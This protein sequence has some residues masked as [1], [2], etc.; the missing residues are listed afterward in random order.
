M[1]AITSTGS[2]SEPCPYCFHGKL[3][4]STTTYTSYG[5]VYDCTNCGRKTYE[6]NTSISIDE[7]FI[8]DK[9]ESDKLENR[10][11]TWF[12]KDKREKKLFNLRKK[13]K[14]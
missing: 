11:E 1:A 7:V 10:R 6:T 12:E 5:K 8:S 9:P 3:K 14:R 4:E 13:R 2:T